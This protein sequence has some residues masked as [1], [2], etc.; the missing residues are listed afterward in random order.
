RF[1]RSTERDGQEMDA[2]ICRNGADE[3]I[4]LAA[5]D[6]RSVDRPLPQPPCGRTCIEALRLDS[7]A[8]RFEQAGCGCGRAAAL[9]P[10]AHFLAGK[11]AKAA[12]AGTGQ[13]VNLLRGKPRHELKVI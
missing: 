9:R 4:R 12:D 11:L 10:Y 2:G 13:D 3:R 1:E 7:D 5:N 8:E 6:H